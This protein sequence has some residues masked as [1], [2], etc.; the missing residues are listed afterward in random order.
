M[1][2]LWIFPLRPSISAV[3]WQGENSAAANLTTTR[4]AGFIQDLARLSR[5]C[6]GNRRVGMANA[7]VVITWIE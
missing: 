7:S 3:A 4:L 2:D 6:Q 5:G 1:L